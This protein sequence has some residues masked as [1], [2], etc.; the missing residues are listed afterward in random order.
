MGAARVHTGPHRR[1]RRETYVRCGRRAGLVLVAAIAACACLA[2]SALAAIPK[3]FVPAPPRA[4]IVGHRVHVF[5]GSAAATPGSGGLGSA[6]G[7]LTSAPGEQTSQLGAPSVSGAGRFGAANTASNTGHLTFLDFAGGSVQHSPVLHLIFWGSN[8]NTTG[9]AL[10]TQLLQMYNDLSGSPYQHILAQYADSQG[11]VTSHV[12]V[13][14]YTDTRVA[15]PSQVDDANIGGN[16]PAQVPTE[17]QNAITAN[18]W[19]RT[20]DSQFIVLPAPGSTYASTLFS[21][22]GT[23]CA[24][25]SE[26]ASNSSYSLVPD[27]NDS[28]FNGFCFHADPHENLNNATSWVAAHEYG[29]SVTDPVFNGYYSSTGNEIGDLCETIY[30][31][32]LGSGDVVTPLWDNAQ[33]ACSVSDSNNY[34]AFAPTVS[35]LDTT[36]GPPSGGT[37]VHIYG[38]NFSGATSVKFGGVAAAS[39]TVTSPSTIIATTPATSAGTV[40]VDVTTP[41]GTNAATAADKYMFA[42]VA[43]TGVGP[44]VGLTGGGTGV[45]IYGWGFTG[46][47]AVNFGST[48][49]A[50]FSV[51]NDTTMTAVS[52]REAAGPV[53]VHVVAPGGTSPVT[54]ADVGGDQFAYGADIVTNVSVAGQFSPE[55]S[56]NGGTSVSITGAGFT[57]ATAVDFGSTAATS[58][59]VNSDGSISAVSPPGSDSTGWVDVRVVVPAGTSPVDPGIDQFLYGPTITGISPSSGPGGGG[60]TVTVTGTGFT[61][62]GG[63]YAVTLGWGGNARPFTIS[64][65]T[66]LTFVTPTQQHGTTAVPYV[67]TN[68]VAG[69]YQTPQIASPQAFTYDT[70]VV[71]AVSPAQG[72]VAGGTTVTINGSGFTNATKLNFGSTV[73]SSCATSAQPCFSVNSDGVITATSPAGSD[74][75]GYVDVRVWGGNLES[76]VNPYDQF[77]YAPTITSISPTSGPSAGGTTVTVT[78]TGFLSDGGVSAAAFVGIGQPIGVTVVS[79]TQLTFVTPAKRKYSVV[80]P[81]VVTNGVSGQT[82]Q[83]QSPSPQSFT[84]T[85]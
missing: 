78:G 63:I 33:A 76:A 68:G 74:S 13:T 85:G 40:D 44:S 2:G 20:A 58:F 61:S 54:P 29:E 57:G 17:V 27:A 19:T 1:N 67:H 15:A 72:P 75:T 43:V 50:S 28:P 55:G 6:A 48:P 49:A 42:S 34:G 83:A 10:K 35:Y 24:Y 82:N 62:D 32:T 52:P 31:Q 5:Y 36:A 38:S 77:I 84:Y 64:S 56:V 9:A 45:T 23:F 39:Y 71:G 3:H 11:Y 25:H 53:D 80:T 7:S 4:L 81:Y 30:D 12:T 70:P 60:T 47:T 41:S 14:S 79:D 8:W 37:T 66:S 18:G 22:V 26:D 73:E 16:G 59:T 46:A 51:T 69:Q 21:Q 65:D